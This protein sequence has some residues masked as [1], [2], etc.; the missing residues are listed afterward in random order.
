TSA[1]CHRLLLAREANLLSA[2]CGPSPGQRDP[3]SSD[4]QQRQ[5][6]RLRGLPHVR[7]WA[8]RLNVLL[9]WGRW[10][11]RGRCR[12]RRRRKELFPPVAMTVA[13]ALKPATRVHRDDPAVGLYS[14][15]LASVIFIVCIRWP[16][17]AGEAGRCPRLGPRLR[18]QKNADQQGQ[19]ER[20]HWPAH[21]PPPCPVG[22]WCPVTGAKR[23]PAVEATHN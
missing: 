14:V 12:C 18:M 21:G 10:C 19:H 23:P 1:P 5:A 3:N 9:P 11:P 8:R 17:F 15:V 13:L 6:A 2:A 4:Q 16:H 20:R 7:Q 22:T